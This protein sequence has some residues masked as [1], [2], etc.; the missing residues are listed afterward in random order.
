MRDSEGNTALHYACA[1]AHF[2]VAL[3]LLRAF[4]ASM[5][6]GGTALSTGAL[7]D[8]ANI[9]ASA[10]SVTMQVRHGQSLVLHVHGS[11]CL[12]RSQVTV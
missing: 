5:H 1:G 3:L 7:H 4:S 8:S 11:S 2:D 6:G 9:T 10:D 12:V